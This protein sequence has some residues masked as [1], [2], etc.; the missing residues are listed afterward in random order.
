VS[1]SLARYYRSEEDIQKLCET[2][3]LTPCPNCKIFGALIFHGR[4]YGYNECDEN[5]RSCR[6]RRVFCSNRKSRNNG[7]GRT[8]SVWAADT[9]KRLR[10]SSKTFWSFV[11]LVFFLGNT[12]QALREAGSPCSISSAYRLWRRFT[13]SQSR[14]RTALVLCCPA[15]ELPDFGQEIAQTLAHLEVVFADSFCPVLEFQIRF[16]TSFL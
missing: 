14:L 9:L 12:A 15:P 4:L 11:N 6:G 1:F 8:F 2:L 7:C 5:Q 3:K 13:N 10:L 16:Q